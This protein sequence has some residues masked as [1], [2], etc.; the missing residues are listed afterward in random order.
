MANATLRDA[1]IVSE[2]DILKRTTFRR[3]RSFTRELVDFK[4][5]KIEAL[6][7]DGLKMEKIMKKLKS[8]LSLCLS[9][10]PSTAVILRHKVRRPNQ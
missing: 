4:V 2:E 1:G 7:F 3:K 5:S 10:I 8:T 9:Q 6:F